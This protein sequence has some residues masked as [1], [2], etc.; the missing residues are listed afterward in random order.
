MCFNIEIYDVFELYTETE[1]RNFVFYLFIF[2]HT[3]RDHFVIGKI[4]FLWNG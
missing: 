1:K 2:E 3:G 4:G